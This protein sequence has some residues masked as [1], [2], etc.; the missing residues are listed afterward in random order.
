MS[1][2]RRDIDGVPAVMRWRARIV[3]TLARR[4]GG[5]AAE[6]R[7]IVTSV[8]IEEHGDQACRVAGYLLLGSADRKGSHLPVTGTYDDR[9][10]KSEGCWRFENR[11]LA[12]DAPLP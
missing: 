3:E 2:V 8:R 10:V 9:F 6:R 1:D 11:C 5:S 7:H 4:H 12:L